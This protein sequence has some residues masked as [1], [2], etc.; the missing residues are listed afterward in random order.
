METVNFPLRHGEQ[1][2]CTTRWK[3]HSFMGAF[4]IFVLA[5][6]QPIIFGFLL[7]LIQIYVGWTGQGKWMLLL[8]AFLF[9][10]TLVDMINYLI[11]QIERNGRI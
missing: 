6:L 1:V 8:G 7:F 11:C 3:A 10:Y 9:L 4:G 2:L 5:M